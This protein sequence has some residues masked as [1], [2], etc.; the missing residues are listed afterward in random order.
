MRKL[1]EAKISALNNTFTLNRRSMF[2]TL[3]DLIMTKVNQDKSEQIL[4]VWASKRIDPDP[5]SMVFNDFSDTCLMKR[6]IDHVTFRYSISIRIGEIRIGLILPSEIMIDGFATKLDDIVRSIAPFPDGKQSPT[7]VVRTVNNYNDMLIDFIYADMRFASMDLV[8]RALGGDNESA[9]LVVDGIFH[10]FNHIGNAVYNA[11]SE[12]GISI[13][14]D[15]FFSGQGARRDIISPLNLYSLSDFLGVE[16]SMISVKQKNDLN[17]HYSVII[18]NM[19]PDRSMVT[20][21]IDDL[22]KSS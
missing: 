6:V 15:H 16:P 20:K 18:P 9:D 14:G 22:I 7:R 19:E 11:I 3:R 13:E 8:L 10:D 4:G 1:P 17:Y 2:S 21:K 5:E 12:A